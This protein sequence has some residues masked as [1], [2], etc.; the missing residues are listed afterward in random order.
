MANESGTWIIYG[1]TGDDPACIHTVE[2]A[3]TYINEVGFLPLFKNDIPGFSL[4]ER[5][6]PEYWWSGDT[7]RDPWEWREIIAGSGQI[8]Y[9]K[10]FDKK[11]GFISKEW[12]PYFANYRR[13]GYDFDALWDDEKASMR[14][15]KIMDLFAEE[16]AD[17]E[18]YSFEVKKNAGFGKEGEKNFEGT[19]T[20]LEM[21]LYLCARDFRQRK[22]KKGESYGWSIA[23]YSTPEHI[24]G[25]DYVTSAYQE[26]PPE[27]WERIVCHMKEK[28]P[29]ATEAQI[30]R[31]LAIS[32][33]DAVQ[34]RKSNRTEPKDWIIPANPKYYDVVGAFEASNIVT[35]KQSSDIH[36]G[37]MIYMYVAAPYSAILYKCRAIEVDIPYEF[38]D[39]NLTLKQAMTVE[40]IEKYEPG[41]WT[42]ERIKQFGVYAVR[43]PRSMP[44]E[45][46][47]EMEVEK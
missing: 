45:L 43:G 10:F 22:N 4:E 40:L 1:V 16:N 6:V 28:Y 46:K 36:V 7:A 41:V 8:V 3:I 11:A 32:K 18:L 2:E 12:L 19:V 35:W 27:S 30:R 24:W 15:K 5:T 31:V 17:A 38:S 9:G 26:T 13:D 37:D 20:D 23:V 14:Q 42:F 34:R 21:K 25:Y 39:E 44:A 29:A 47:R 33:G